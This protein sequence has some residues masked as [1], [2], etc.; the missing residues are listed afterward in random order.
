MPPKKDDKKK[1][2]KAPKKEVDILAYTRAPIVLPDVPLAI[3]PLEEE[4][5]GKIANIESL[6]PEWEITGENWGE[7]LA[8]EAAPAIE[9]PSHISVSEYKGLKNFLGLEDIE[10]AVDPK[11]KKPPAKDAK[12]AAPSADMEELAIDEGGR[13]LPRMF[14]FPDAPAE[15]AE[16]GFL[17]QPSTKLFRREMSDAQ[18]ACHEQLSILRA[19]AA[20]AAGRATDPSDPEASALALRAE[21]YQTL[22]ATMLASPPAG[23]EIDPL[24]CAV[25]HILARYCPSVVKSANDSPFSLSN[26]T[27]Y[28]WRSIY[29]KLPSGR[30]C[31]NPAGKYMVRLFLAGKWRK[32]AVTDT[33]P[34]GPTSLPAIASSSNPLELWPMILA[35]AVYSVYTACG[36][37]RSLSDVNGQLNSSL[38]VGF[39]VHLLTGWTPSTPW[40][41]PL[42]MAD[43]QRVKGSLDG[44]LFGGVSV[45][46]PNQIPGVDPLIAV[47]Q[48]AAL[49]AA[50]EAAA[51][52]D[53]SI[54]TDSTSPQ[55]EPPLRTKQFFKELYRKRAEERAVIVSSI[56]QRERRIAEMEAIIKRQV[57]EEAFLL[58]CKDADGVVNVHP[59]LGLCFTNDDGTSST[60][61][62]IRVLIH[63]ATGA[64]PPLLAE[65]K[66]SPEELV[67]ESVLDKMKRE[68]PPLPQS[69]PLQQSWVSLSSLVHMDTFIFALD[70]RLKTKH[71]AALGWHW[72]APAVAIDPKAAKD[73]KAKGGVAPALANDA[74]CI[75]PGQLPPVFLKI[76]T[77]AFFVSPAPVVSDTTDD[78]TKA[79]LAAQASELQSFQD[80]SGAALAVQK[81]PLSSHLSISINIHADMLVEQSSIPSHVV[82][83]LQE[84]LPRDHDPLVMR[85]E[86]SRLQ[87][88]PLMRA[89]FHIPAANVH[90]TEP[91]LF[92]VRLFTTSSVYLTFGC[93]VEVAVG[94]AG[95]IWAGIGGSVLTREGESGATMESTEQM[96]FKIPLQL[97]D[98]TEPSDDT[99]VSFVHTSSRAVGECISTLFVGDGPRSLTENGLVYPRIEHNVLKVSSTIPRLLIGRVFPDGSTHIPPFKWKVTV[100]TK[101]PLSEPIAPVAVG[102]VTTKFSGKYIPNHELVLFRDVMA[103]DKNS[104]PAA[105]RISTGMLLGQEPAATASRVTGGELTIKLHNCNDLTNVDGASSGKSDPFVVMSVGTGD[106]MQR[107][108]SRRIA[109]D[110]NPIFNET[111]VLQWD[112]FSPLSISVV[113]H[114]QLKNDDP[115][116]DFSIDLLGFDFSG[117]RVMEVVNR[118]LENTASGTVSLDITF[119]PYEA[120]VVP[121]VNV[122]LVEGVHLVLSVYR[123]SD[124]RLVAQYRG[125]GL[126]QVYNLAVHGLLEDGEEPPAPVPATA[127]D[128]KA[129]APPKKD[130]KKGGKGG[131]AIVEGL[132]VLFELKVDDAAMLI[133]VDWRSRLPYKFCSAAATDDSTHAEA[134]PSASEPLVKVP[135][136]APK[137]TWQLDVLSGIVNGCRGDT[138]DIETLTALK[139]A[140]EDAQEGRAAKAAAAASLYQERIRMLQAAE[141]GERV[142]SETVVELLSTA[143]EK[144]PEEMRAREI[145]L[146][147]ASEVRSC[148]SHYPI[149]SCIHTKAIALT[150]I[151]SYPTYHTLPT[152]QSTRNTLR[153]WTLPKLCYLPRKLNPIAL[154]DKRIK[155]HRRSTPGRA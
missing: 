127:V 27:E 51:T 33:V 72:N 143:L 23:R 44:M 78:E 154:N 36:Y 116:G 58:V 70:T 152:M 139:N 135:H 45:I 69:T 83:V 56:D 91:M 46:N 102:P 103:I 88:I 113:D 99:A 89:T 109:N 133:P 24:M 54:P 138:K 123:K 84:F 67:K 121:D 141:D 12:K 39:A 31:Y 98:Q 107:V 55:K 126:L 147:A 95:D 150:L 50:A 59:V 128:P 94:E 87:G 57:F 65:K 85:V 117:G 19:E 153:C 26:S 125:R 25:F 38:F 62:D 30:P 34:V 75:H 130:D 21:E 142:V 14:L 15:M 136:V 101:K 18:K 119:T 1:A 112:G 149:S 17:P 5:K 13:A 66:L 37:Q 71:S 20:E 48:A 4:V 148:T 61:A 43:T 9:Y 104:F 10:V 53:P 60:L 52:V 76:N 64:P 28:L 92:W 11:A 41:L 35:K 120:K 144:E 63:W 90:Q 96:L 42:T 100:L 132:E 81:I 93:G 146:N 7:A 108:C 131:S 111:H 82:V 29:P 110:L 77:T 105:F 155:M 6:F 8:P 32:I 106:S 80:E 74:E 145:A 114:D 22:H 124:R 97:Q 129:K 118:A 86:L 122:D 137:F 140:W 3:A 115:L 16:T 2:G 47:A 79:A 40:S 151:Y 134:E 49:E 73:P 68:T